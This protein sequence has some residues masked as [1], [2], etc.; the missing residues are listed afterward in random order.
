MEGPHRKEN[1]MWPDVITLRDFYST[2]LGQVVRRMIRRRLREILP[3]VKGQNMIAI[4]YPTPFLRY[5]R[6]EARRLAAFM[7]VE[8]GALSWSR[9]IPN[10]AVLTE[11]SQLPLADK[12]VDLALVVH[13]LEHSSSPR[14]MIREVWR[15]LADGGRLILIVPN[16]TSIWARFEK[17]PFGYG[18]PYNLSQ[19]NQFLLENMFTPLRAEHALYIPPSQSRIFLSA[20]SAWEKLGHK[21]FQTLSGVLILKAEKQV[22]AGSRVEEL[23]WSQKPQLAKKLALDLL[24]KLKN[25]RR[26]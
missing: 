11:P 10:I 2:R 3:D 7:P 14:E 13:A 15:V 18:H 8:Q 17:T 5:Y 22:Y 21:W 25:V 24:E 12:S 6:E 16:R 20:A 9:K 26:D 19:L 4:G 23:V 1:R